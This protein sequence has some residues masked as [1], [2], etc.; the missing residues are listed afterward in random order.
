MVRQLANEGTAVIIVEHRVEDVLDSMPDRVLYLEGG[1]A[2]YLGP[3]DGFLS[4]ADPAAVKVP[5]AVSLTRARDASPEHDG[6][7]RRVSDSTQSRPRLEWRGVD[8]GYDDRVV[9]HGIT[10][11]LGASER[12]AVLGPNG[13]GKTTLFKAAI[14]LI[15]HRTGEVMVDGRPTEG[16]SVADLAAIFGYVFQNPSQMLFAPRVEDEILFGPRNLGRD[17]DRF[18]T[19]VDTAL[20]R[21]SLLAEHEI[22]DRPPLTLSFG[23]QKRLAIAVALALEPRTL[24]LDEPSAGQ[25]HRSATAFM[26]EVGRIDGLESVYFVTHDADLALAHADR[27]LLMRNGRIVADG[28]PLEVIADRERWAGC[29]LRYTSLMEANARWGSA[30][31]RFLAADELAQWVVRQDLEGGLEIT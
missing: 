25:D 5:F 17:P 2:R 31:G 10:A 7:A 4:I 11:S 28:A 9:L 20:E 22:R 1:A 3:M 6:G 26:Q 27:I 21:V 23:Q 15:P 19:L 16:R 12:V 14:G 29:N 13:S 24:V 18:S 8:A 30:T